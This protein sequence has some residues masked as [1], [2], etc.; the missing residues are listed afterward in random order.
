MLKQRIQELLESWGGLSAWEISDAVSSKIGRKVTVDEVQEVLHRRRDLFKA[1]GNGTVRWSLRRPDDDAAPKAAAKITN[2][3]LRNDVPEQ[4]CPRCGSPMTVRFA[5]R[6]RNAGKAFLGCTRFPVCKGSA[7]LDTADEDGADQPRKARAKRVSSPAPRQPQAGASSKMRVG[8]LVVSTYNVFGPGKAV[9]QEGKDSI[10]VEYFDHP[11]QEADERY[12][13]AVPRASLKRLILNH[14]TRVFWRK[15]GVWTAGRV[16]RV[17]EQRD[18]HV[19]AHEWE[20]FVAERELFVRWQRPLSD[21]VGFGAAGLLESPLLANRRRPFLQALLRQ[22]AAAHG[23]SGILSSSIEFHSHQVE[24]ARRILED[25]VQRYLLADEVG[26]GKTI[27]A[28]MVIR[29][30]LLDDAALRVQLI[31]PPF[32]VAQW[33]RELEGKFHTHTYERASMRFSRDDE[34]DSWESADLVVV[35]EAHNLAR[36][37]GSPDPHLAGRYEQLRKVALD[38][39]RLLMLSATPVLHNEG[40]LLAML[41]LLDPQVYRDSDAEDLRARVEARSVLG[42]N[43]LGLRAHLPAR[44]VRSR[45]TELAALFP[46][47]EDVQALVGRAGRQLDEE[48]KEG[49]EDTIRSLRIHVS[50]VYRLHR[51]MLRTRRTEALSTTYRVTGRRAPLTH[52]RD[53]RV[54]AGVDVLVDEWRQELLAAAESGTLTLDGAARELG[55]AC[56]LASDPSCLARWARDRMGSSAADGEREALER[57]ARGAGK[58]DRSA[59]LVAPL[60]DALTYELAE[61][62]RMVVF[63]VTEDLA[64]ELT[65]E[66]RDLIGDELIR[67]HVSSDDAAETEEAI[68]DFATASG[69]SRVLV[70]D[71]S[72]EEGRN[73]Q[74]ADLLVHVGLPADVNRLEQRIGR[75]DRWHVIDDSTPWRSILHSDPEGSGTLLDAW[76]LVLA[77]GFGVFERSVA[78]L[79]HAVEVAGLTAWQ[80]LLSR[81]APGAAD[82]IAQ[83]KGLL[84][85]EVER[86]R[87][88]DAL[89]AIEA[90]EDDRSVFGQ[91]Q[92][93]EDD[94]TAFAEVTDD[95]MA[96]RGEPGNLRFQRVGDPVNA[97]GAYRVRGKDARGEPVFP[98]VPTWRIIRDFV[99]LEGVI[100]TFRRDVAVQR[101]ATQVYRY[102]APLIDAAADFLWHDDRG[103]AFGMWRWVPGWSHPE[104]P[105]YRFDYHVEAD[106]EAWASVLYA[107]GAHVDAGA[108]QR[109]ADA[110][111]PPVIVSLWLDGQGRPIDDDDLLTALERPYRKPARWDDPE[112][113]DFSL[114]QQRIRW[115]YDLVPADR[116]RDAWRDVEVAAEGMAMSHP[117]VV[118]SIERG[119][120]QARL[121]WENRLHQLRLRAV[122]AAAKERGALDEEIAFERALADAIQPGIAEPQA[123]LDSTG[124]VIVSGHVPGFEEA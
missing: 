108:L 98:L 106:A 123:R 82:A 50:E 95:L 85:E 104:R 105:A 71:R 119:Q 26:L 96:E 31:L 25:P 88:Q 34:P 38:S 117:A 109:R 70:C 1:E 111:L 80:I 65:R 39:P 69:A 122:R 75:L 12:R 60:A 74:F 79:Q 17:T 32:L 102:G 36:L 64:T 10:V 68:Q 22:R 15:D 45:L 77:E 101:S 63:C 118:Q 58:I 30:L 54:A 27:E 84:E 40:I 37:S 113:G 14:E 6:G 49:L 23:M 7:S 107:G 42:R 78:S 103:R 3:A 47:D 24:I 121:L 116:W 87:E 112:G 76:R 97:T 89:D 29:Q 56:E 81:G 72:A 124:L 43:L 73:F 62:E 67:T 86:I 61:R 120:T 16:V 115:A 83:V 4:N 92:A 51:R 46:E 41:K 28:G 99:P 44:L 90:V 13:E 35:D 114:N 55:R 110:V 53:Q 93:I 48:E 57:M 5:T 11:G 9:A 66:L 52:P 8:D 94:A 19:R 18:I 2:P 100:G 91:I 33:R 20:G 59:E 21:P